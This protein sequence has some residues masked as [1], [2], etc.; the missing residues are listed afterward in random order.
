MACGPAA[1]RHEQ[2]SSTTAPQQRDS[3]EPTGDTP[4]FDSGKKTDMRTYA[5]TVPQ[6]KSYDTRLKKNRTVKARFITSLEA[7]IRLNQV[8]QTVVEMAKA[9]LP[10]TAPAVREAL[11]WH[12]IPETS[13]EVALLKRIGNAPLK[14][15]IE[16]CLKKQAGAG[17]NRYGIAVSKIAGGEEIVVVTVKSR[18]SLLPI[19]RRVDGPRKLRL[20]GSVE[21]TFKN[22]SVA[23]SDPKG[24]TFKPKVKKVEDRFVCSFKA[25]E[26]GIW[27]IEIL[28]DGPGGP[29]TLANFPVAVG[30]PVKNSVTL[31]PSELESQ[32]TKVLEKLLFNAINR[33]RRDS[34]LDAF[35]RSKELAEVSRKYSSEMDE[36]GVVA[37]ISPISGSVLDRTRAA[38]IALAEVSENLAR[39]GT[40]RE[41]H[42]GL[43]TSP[44]H[45]ANILNPRYQQVGIG[46]VL[47]K[48][49]GA[50][51]VIVT[52]IFARKHEPIDPSSV[53]DTVI[54]M[55]N[56]RRSELGHQRLDE[57]KWLR[58][59]AK[60]A[61][62]K[63]FNDDMPPI[64]SM[65]SPFKNVRGIRFETTSLQVALSSVKELFA[66]ED[67]HIGINVQKGRDNALDE[68]LVCVVVLLG[69]KIK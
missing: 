50:A 3:F 43:M 58:R 7:D 2:T 1:P 41:A 45:R 30:V 65:E 20:E 56:R 46:V 37:H 61:G 47:S 52:Q 32:D 29:T 26:N 6:A 49:E 25:S 18:L 42:D 15:D 59:T 55:I 44:A 66:K 39:A 16:T 9:G 33:E 5:F 34:G 69:Q 17:S 8:A 67:T 12:G 48:E 38:R 31:A 23:L 28:G 22:I 64:K 36:T 27:Q 60:E 53:S 57:H 11:W 40:A 62:R 24:K 63:C 10:I 35:K 51:P 4:V 68:E 19:S 14:E 54:Q 13:H 21:P